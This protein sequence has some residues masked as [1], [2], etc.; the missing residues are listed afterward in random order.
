MRQQ[1]MSLSELKREVDA[2]DDAIHDLLIREG[3]ACRAHCPRHPGS[4]VQRGCAAIPAPR[5]RSENPAPPRRSG[6]RAIY[7][8]VRSSISGA[9]SSLQ[10]LAQR[11]WDGP[12]L[13]R[14]RCGPLPRSRPHLFRFADGD[15]EPQLRQLRR[16]R[17]RR[18]PARHRHRAARRQRR[19]GR[20]MVESFYG[21]GG[22]SRAACRGTHSLYPRR[23]RRGH[24]SAGVRHRD[25][26][27]RKKPAMTRHCCW[28]KPKMKSA[29][30]DC[31]AF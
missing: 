25:A 16:S 2:V 7:R 12:C 26:R 27:S 29:A 24:F 11:T 3:R 30:P 19:R 5:R 1:Q 22:A 20:C 28:S 10:H 8:S 21:A 9:R 6:I 14:R 18:R 15:G 31:R 4:A 17:L 23:R 13:R